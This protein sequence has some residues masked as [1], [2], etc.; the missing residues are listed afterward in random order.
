MAG[1]NAKIAP[2]G[3]NSG[4]TPAQAYAAW[5][6]MPAPIRHRLMAAIGTICPVAV[7]GSYKA[8]VAK[9]HSPQSAEQAVIARID[10]TDSMAT[11]AL[12]KERATWTLGE[13]MKAGFQRATTRIRT[14]KTAA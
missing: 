8:L 6:A 2:G 13:D 10:L 7:F 1:H 14:G 4:V 9:G 12:D 5:D 11:Q 3:R